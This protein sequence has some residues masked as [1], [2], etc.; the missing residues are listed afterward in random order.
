M[1]RSSRASTLSVPCRFAFTG[2][3]AG[4]FSELVVGLILTI[5]TLGLYSPWFIC[6]LADWVA[7]YTRL[8]DDRG[9][10]VNFA[11]VGDGGDLFATL[12]V[13]T[14]LT[15]FTLGIYSFW[16]SVNLTRFCLENLV[17]E[18]SNGGEIDISF[19][20]TGADLFARVFVDYILTI[21]TLGIYTP[22]MICNLH[23]FYYEN[24][25]IHTDDTRLTLTFTG[26]GGE[27]FVTYI[28]GYILTLLTL[29]LYSF[30]FQVNLMRF[31]SGNTSV[32]TSSGR[33]YRVN[34]TGTGAEFFVINVVGTV[35]SFLTLGIYYFWFLNNLIRFQTDYLEVDHAHD[36]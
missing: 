32:T 31:T 5:F 10:S 15:F 22:W 3:G 20:G 30:W 13:G 24:T 14:I 12:I 8:K 1:K 28:V 2:T 34:F 26:T 18:D 36:N 17:A 25:R 21:V 29:G 33:R 23:G 19:H 7:R 9:R 11:F 6:R 27:L 35:L 4:L 16:F